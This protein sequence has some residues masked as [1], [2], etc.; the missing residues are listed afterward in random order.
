M[1]FNILKARLRRNMTQQELAI[2]ANISR[3]TLSKLESGE[4]VEVKLGTLKSL[5][6]ALNCSVSNLFV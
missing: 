6:K 3:A 4:E 5:A 2:K 1:T